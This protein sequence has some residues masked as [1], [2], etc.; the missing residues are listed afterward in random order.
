VPQKQAK[1]PIT[2]L[3]IPHSQRRPISLRFPTW[4]LSVLLFLL[5]ILL[6]GIGVFA[7]RYYL[8]TQELAELRR[9]RDSAEVRQQE[10]RETILSQHE[11][12]KSLEYNFNT[13]MDAVQ[14]DYNALYRRVAEFQQS[15]TEQ[16]QQF[17]NELQQIERLT[18]EVRSLVGLEEP[19]PTPTAPSSEDEQSSLGGIGAG[20]TRASLSGTGSSL[21]LSVQ[22]VLNPSSNPTVQEL[23][24]LHDSL[25]ARL[26]ELKH[27][28]QQVSERISVIEP[29]KR[30]S[31]EELERQL[32]LWDAAP[33]GWPLSGRI[34]STFGYRVFRGK[35]DFHTG[36][37]IAV[38]YRTPVA[39]TA[40]GVVIAAGWQSGY[41]WSVEI[42]HAEGWSTLYGHLSRYLVDVGDHVKRGQIIGLSGSSGNSTGPHLH[43]EIRLNGVPIDPWRYATAQLDR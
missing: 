1:E 21:E 6:A 4:A 18:D 38:W 20:L 9:V 25:P 36:I 17:R 2:L 12:V 8:L 33:K 30:T 14:R 37:D 22:E 24:T 19:T 5:V 26:S 28:K 43:Y 3:I 29:E 7:T 40:D 15:L 42:Q 39:A 31:P 27:L 32:R 13:Q 16:V 11:E 34:T 10:L 41:G 35:R 23:Q